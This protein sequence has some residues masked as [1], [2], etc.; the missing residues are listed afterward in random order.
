MQNKYDLLVVGAGAAGLMAAGIAANKGVKVLVLEKMP[1]PAIKLRITGKGRC[2]LTNAAPLLEFMDHF[3]RN[4]RFL[5]QAFIHFF[6]DELVTFFESIG[7][8]TGI[9]R[10][11]RVFPLSNS[12]KEIVDA[13]E[14]W[15]KQNGA[16]IMLNT[17]V[18]GLLAEEAKMQGVRMRNK[19]VKTGTFAI[20]AKAVLIATGGKS[21]PATGSTGDGY[22]LAQSVGHTII[23]ILPALVPLETAG[24]T[25]RK[26]QGLSL[27]N[28]KVILW[29]NNKKHEEQFGEMLFTHFGLSGPVI[30]TVSKHVSFAL[31]E[32][33]QVEISIDLKPALS[34]EKLDARLLRDLNEHGKMKMHSLLKLLLPQKMISVCLELTGIPPDKLAN[35][36]SA[37]ERKKLR[38]WL[39]DFR[40]QIKSNRP[41]KE[42]IITAGGVDTKEVDPRTMQSKLVQGLY[43]AGEI[44]D[45][46]ADT[47]GFNLQAA[48]STGWVA[49][50]AVAEDRKKNLLT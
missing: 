45:I 26:L 25:A 11:G 10:G 12:A 19:N 48:F 46:D 23:P 43:F 15:A 7:V 3:G 20:Y 31:K 8:K 30:L 27:K 21:Y 34:E 16:K 49:A 17:K 32:S 9:E 47:G 37:Q 40:L 39:K 22:W 13:L 50:N 18:V 28:I 42:A 36:V 14:K 33:Q 2:N 35:Q 41:F 5:R 44:L 24:E 6:S 29:I 38:T 1:R 4:G